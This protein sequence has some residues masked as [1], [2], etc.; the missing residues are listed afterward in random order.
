M[1]TFIQA[2][3]LTHLNLVS[4]LALFILGPNLLCLGTIGCQGPVKAMT[5]LQTHFRSGHDPLTQLR[6]VSLG[7]IIYL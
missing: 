5:R 6:H 1:A 4:N 2:G 7:L 3:N